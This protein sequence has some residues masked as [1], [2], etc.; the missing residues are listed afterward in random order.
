MIEIERHIEILLLSNDCVVVPGLGGFVAHHMDA[1]Y[2]TRDGLFLPPLRTLGFNPQLTMNDSLLAQSYVEVYDISYPQAMQ[3]IEQDVN[4]L[5]E[6]LSNEGSY[7]MHD[8]GRLYINNEGNTA[9][10]PCEAGILTPAYYGLGGFEMQPLQLQNAQPSMT[11]TPSQPQEQP[12]EKKA[13]LVAITTDEQTGQKMVSV[14]VK[15]LR[16]VAVAAVLITALFFLASPLNN[17]PKVF[18]TETLQ[19]SVLFNIF[20]DHSN[21]K[22]KEPAVVTNGTTAATET[23]T[24][25]TKPAKKTKPAK[26]PAAKAG[27]QAEQWVIVLCSHVGEKNANWLVGELAKEDITA[28]VINAETGNAKV[29]YGSY[30]TKEKAQEALTAMRSNKRFEQGWLLQTK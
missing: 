21:D 19:S 22:V 8:I 29:V 7:E 14:S 23:T 26:A 16:N 2:D 9:F 18:S 28:R 20:A 1:R 12:A 15:A 4:L 27:T 25:N 5:K 30:P 17:N 11:N 3:R 24:T 13:R 6:Q 10:T